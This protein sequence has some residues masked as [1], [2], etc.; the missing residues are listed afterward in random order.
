MLM[1]YVTVLEIVTISRRKEL[2]NML[3]NETLISIMMSEAQ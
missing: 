3:L 2:D 1:L